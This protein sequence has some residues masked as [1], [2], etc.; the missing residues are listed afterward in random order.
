MISR[1]KSFTATATAV[2][3][4]E[5]PGFMTSFLQTGL[6]GNLSAPPENQFLINGS[7]A[8]GVERAPPL[9]GSALLFSFYHVVRKGDWKF[10]R[11]TR[12]APQLHPLGDVDPILPDNQYPFLELFNLQADHREEHNLAERETA[13]M[14]ELVSLLNSIEA[15]SEDSEWP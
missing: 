3:K 7:N 14:D 8:A 4:T 6:N 11:W 15:H 1:T 13:R 9:L 2:E 12:Q 5:I 10:I